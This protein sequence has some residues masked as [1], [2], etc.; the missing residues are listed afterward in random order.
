[1]FNKKNSLFNKYK[2]PVSFLYLK[3]MPNDEGVLVVLFETFNQRKLVF[4]KRNRKK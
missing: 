4:N 1:M 3:L 2:P